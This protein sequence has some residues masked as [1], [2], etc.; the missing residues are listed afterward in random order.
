MNTP[1]FIPAPKY[2]RRFGRVRSALKGKS[3]VFEAPVKK[4]PSETRVTA[5]MIQLFPALPKPKIELQP[6]VTPKLAQ[7]VQP[8]KNEKTKRLPRLPRPPRMVLF[9]FFVVCSIAIASILLVPTLY[10]TAFPSDP[11]PVK[12]EESGTPLGGD[13]TA[14]VQHQ[15]RQITLPEYDAKLPNGEW[16]IVPRIGLRTQLVEG[17]NSDEALAK[18]VWRVPQFGQAGDTSKPMILA[19]H[20]FGYKWWWDND[21]W[22]SHSFYLLPKL[23]PGDLVEVI[24]DHRKYFYEIYAGEEGEEITDFNADLIMYTCKFLNSPIRH[25]RYARMIDPSGSPK[26]SSA[27]LEPDTPASSS[28][29]AGI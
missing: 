10:Y 20:R 25:F 29:Q 2:L 3:T 18:G 21:Y 5:P 24:S 1:I 4:V 27:N 7:T 12:A 23:E 17:E 14:G 11:I 6:P 15:T 13:F 19:A 22:R 28:A 26:T 9:T 8:S 16:L